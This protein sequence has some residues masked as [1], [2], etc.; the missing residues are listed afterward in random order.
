MISVLY[1]MH[2]KLGAAQ[3]C[4]EAKIYSRTD[5][6]SDHRLQRSTHGSHCAR[7]SK[8]QDILALGYF[9][10][11]ETFVVRGDRKSRSKI[12]C[13]TTHNFFAPSSEKKIPKFLSF[14]WSIS[15]YDAAAIAKFGQQC[16]IIHDYHTR[17]LL[18][19]FS[20]DRCL[21]GCN[22]SFA[23]SQVEDCFE[24]IF[25]YSDYQTLAHLSCNSYV[26]W[27][28]GRAT[29]VQC[30]LSVR[31]SISPSIDDC[32]CLYSLVYNHLQYY[33]ILQPVWYRF[34]YLIKMFNYTLF[35]FHFTGS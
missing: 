25:K 11:P 30:F 15:P 21:N 26:C 9:S 22:V 28:S 31:A 33:K 29:R 19:F 18:E 13:K 27:T 34:T 1:Y 24:L 16:D 17:L 10:I 32:M 12:H 23:K 2:E 7:S 8:Q 5:V 20:K 4:L 35:V 14:H 6:F 3:S